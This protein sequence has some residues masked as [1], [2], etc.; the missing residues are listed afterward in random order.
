MHCIYMDTNILILTRLRQYPEWDTV[1]QAAF[2]DDLIENKVTVRVSSN[3]LRHVEYSSFSRI[4]VHMYTPQ[5]HYA[6]L[7]EFSQR[8]ATA[9]RAVRQSDCLTT[10][11][12]ASGSS[13]KARF[14][15]ASRQINQTML[16]NTWTGIWRE[17]VKSTNV[18]TLI[19]ILSRLKEGQ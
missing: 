12:L 6:V 10:H 4:I 11:T 13:F 19:E 15:R 5:S 16:C 2:S 14:R 7:S 17:Y 8:F 1:M 18:N 9:T 3:E